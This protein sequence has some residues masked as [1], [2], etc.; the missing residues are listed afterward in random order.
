VVTFG[1]ILLRLKAPGHEKLFQS[2]AF[3]ATF[4]GGEANVAV[5]LANFGLDAAF[6]IA[7]PDNDIVK[8]FVE[9]GTYVP[10]R[11]DGALDKCL[12]QSVVTACGTPSYSLP[13]THFVSRTNTA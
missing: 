10:Y 12:F 11:N 9:K 5:S 6:V 13:G 2:P 8:T 1:E 7:L 4:G 3:E